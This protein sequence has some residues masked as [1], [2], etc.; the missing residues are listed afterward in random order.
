MTAL[1]YTVPVV[2]TPNSVFDGNTASALQAIP[3]W[4]NG[5]SIDSTNITST[6]A[7][8]LSVNTASAVRRAVLNIPSSQSTSSTSF[9]PLSTADTLT[10]NFA[11]PPELALFWYQATWSSTVANAGS[12]AIFTAHHSPNSQATIAPASGAGGSFI[13]MTPAT[14]SGS[15]VVTP[16]TSSPVGL[17]SPTLTGNYT[18]DVTTGQILGAKQVGLAGPCLLL[19]PTSG[20]LN[21]FTVSVWFSASSGNVTVANRTL[22]LL[23]L[24]FG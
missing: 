3:T 12:A 8:S 13:T 19:P 2:G 16:L 17:S 21:Q 22:W 6:F 5:N 7:N 1:S 20:V 10:V 15:G 14:T 23:L 18:G 11:Q 24:N 4:A 9:T